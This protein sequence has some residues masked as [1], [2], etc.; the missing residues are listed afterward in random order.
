RRPGMIALIVLAVVGTASAVFFGAVGRKQAAAG[1]SAPPGIPATV[2][3]ATVEDVPL[4]FDA[5]GTVE[6][7]S[8]VSVTSQ[9]NGQMIKVYFTEAKYV[10]KG[11]M[12]FPIHPRPSEAV[13]AGSVANQSKAVGQQRQAEANLAKDQA[14]ARTA[15]VE[16]KRYETLYERGIIS[17]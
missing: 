14:Q 17:K 11:D 2:A 5:I 16:A 12:L 6:A 10:K 3:A 13:V 15:D 7:F 9:A 1:P 8:T 4:T